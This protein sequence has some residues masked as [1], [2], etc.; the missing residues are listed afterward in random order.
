MKQLSA[1]QEGRRRIC[2][3][4]EQ[5]LWEQSWSRVAENRSMHLVER[6]ARW[7]KVEL[8]EKDSRRLSLFEGLLSHLESIQDQGYE[9]AQPLQER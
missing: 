5:P 9:Q 4:K 6:R 3:E 1:K 2:R 7:K 8:R